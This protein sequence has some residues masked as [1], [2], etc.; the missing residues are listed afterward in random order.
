MN[1]LLPENM[2][3]FEAHKST[4]DALLAESAALRQEEIRLAKAF[5]KLPKEVATPEAFEL[6]MRDIHLAH[7]E[8]NQRL[9][10]LSQDSVE[11]ELD[12]AKQTRC[13]LIRENDQLSQTMEK[14]RRELQESEKQ[15]QAAEK[16]L[17]EIRRSLRPLYQD[18]WEGCA[19]PVPTLE[20]LCYHNDRIKEDIDHLEGDLKDMDDDVESLRKQNAE[21]EESCGLVFEQVNAV[22]ERMDEDSKGFFGKLFSQDSMQKY[23]ELLNELRQRVKELQE[24]SS[25][26]SINIEQ[27]QSHVNDAHKKTKSSQEQSESM[28]KRMAKDSSLSKALNRLKKI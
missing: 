24:Y 12:A 2:E 3:L 19:T 27:L 7:E 9:V 1:N 16:T 10:H 21:L 22:K 18:V 14:I 6:F 26:F 13:Q 8:L 4:Y 11:R 5:S 15:R 25:S 17:E 20:I 23:S 28:R